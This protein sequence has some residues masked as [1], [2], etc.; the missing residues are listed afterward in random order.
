M[1]Q[2]PPAAKECAEYAD[3]I[4]YSVDDN[5]GSN[6]KHGGKQFERNVMSEQFAEKRPEFHKNALLITKHGRKASCGISAHRLYAF[7]APLLNS[8]Q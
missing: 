6:S 5:D 1:F 3:M 7:F 4:S 2:I 8:F